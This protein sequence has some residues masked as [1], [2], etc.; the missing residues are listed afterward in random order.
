MYSCSI[1]YNHKYGV[2]QPSL[3]CLDAN[4]MDKI[5]Y[6]TYQSNHISSVA[7]VNKAST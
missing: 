1:L 4:I 6:N 2:K 3:R 5:G 7:E